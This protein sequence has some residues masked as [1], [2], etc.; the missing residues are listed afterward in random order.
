VSATPVA[1]QEA[2]HEI[3][4]QLRAML[5]DIESGHRQ[6]PVRPHAALLDERIAERPAYEEVMDSRASVSNYF[7]E[8][9]GP[10]VLHEIHDD[11]TGARRAHE[12]S[13][14]KSW[15]LVPRRG[16]RALRSKD[17]APVRFQD[18]LDRGG[19]PRIG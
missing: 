5:R 17:G 3:H 14:D 4:E 16:H 19:D 6:Q 8:W 2:D 12:L 13:P 11:E 9:F 10:S 15:G 18:A 7:K 1:A